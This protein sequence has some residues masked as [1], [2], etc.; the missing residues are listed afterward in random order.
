[1]NPEDPWDEKDDVLWSALTRV[2]EKKYESGWPWI[3]SEIV[4]GKKVTEVLKA[5]GPQWNKTRKSQCLS[6][7]LIYP[8]TSLDV[9]RQDNRKGA[10]AYGRC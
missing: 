5:A 6:E 8:F 7:L 3:I 9:H 4:L 1:M 2:T 10:G